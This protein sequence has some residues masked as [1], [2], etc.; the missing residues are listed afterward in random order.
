MMVFRVLRFRLLR[1]AWSADVVM[2]R[3]QIVCK[4][5]AIHDN[6]IMRIAVSLVVRL[7]QGDWKY[8]QISTNIEQTG[9]RTGYCV[10]TLVG[11]SRSAVGRRL[12]TLP[13]GLM[14]SKHSAPVYRGRC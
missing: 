3:W 1:N 6:V 12:R 7:L 13:G 11:S 10:P 9:D 8:T 14:C 2:R 4:A 5:D